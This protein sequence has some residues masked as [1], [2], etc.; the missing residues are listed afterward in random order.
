MDVKVKCEDN[1]ITVV[2]MQEHSCKLH[3]NRDYFLDGSL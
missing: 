3:Y 2:E 1:S